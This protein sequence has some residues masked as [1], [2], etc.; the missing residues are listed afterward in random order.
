MSI[1]KKQSKKNKMLESFLAFY[2]HLNVEQTEILDKKTNLKNYWLQ[3]RE[4][5]E[6]NAKMDQIAKFVT[7]YISDRK[8]KN[9]E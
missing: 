8:S 5:K 6:R 3:K 1:S 9:K 2:L 7:R 4:V